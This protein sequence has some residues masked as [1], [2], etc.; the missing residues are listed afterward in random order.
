MSSTA[1]RLLFC[2]LALAGLAAPARGEHPASNLDRFRE[3][4]R[5]IGERLRNELRLPDSARVRVTVLPEDLAWTIDAGFAAAFA[6]PGTQ[7][8]VTHEVR[9]AL[10]EG[11]VEYG[12]PE[13]DGLFGERQVH[14]TVR[15][16]LSV[17]ALASGEDTPLLRGD[18]ADSSSDRIA[19]ADI[20]RVEHPSLAITRGRSAPEGFLSGILEP[21][22]LVGALGVA[23]VLL[24]QVRS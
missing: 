21:L 24:F 2:C 3:L 4:A 12:A 13:R 10:R 16:L 5:A 19:A 22:I 1:I 20:E 9:A 15:L 23:V 7:G 18:R 6:S 11:H 17:E 14:R 8:T